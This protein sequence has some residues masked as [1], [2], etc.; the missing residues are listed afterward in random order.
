MVDM[1]GKP[2]RDTAV[3]NL[4]IKAQ[5]DLA[6]GQKFLG[7]TARQE[8]EI[9]PIAGHDL[10]SG[11]SWQSIRQDSDVKNT[12][13]RQLAEREGAVQLPHEGRKQLMAAA[14]RNWNRI[15]S[16]C[17]EETTSLTQAVQELS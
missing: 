17:P 9:L 6:S 8:V 10:S 14:M 16:R 11:W 7:L 4:V 2:G 12:Y 15:K 13:F 3:D 1:D 5:A